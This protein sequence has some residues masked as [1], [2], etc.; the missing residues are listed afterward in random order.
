MDEPLFGCFFLNGWTDSVCCWYVG[1]WKNPPPGTPTHHQEPDPEHQLG[2]K[3]TDLDD[4]I[5][6]EN[7]RVV[8]IKPDEVEQTDLSDP[9][10]AR[11]WLYTFVVKPGEGGEERGRWE[12]EELWP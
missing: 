9:T 4:P 5:A 3:V 11:R 12:V 2:Q 1:T 8:I 10:K 7:F 6:R